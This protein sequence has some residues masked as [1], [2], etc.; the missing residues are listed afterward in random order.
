MTNVL[1][2]SMII[3]F[4]FLIFSLYF[5]KI[6]ALECETGKEFWCG[7]ACMGY[8][9]ICTCGENI[10]ANGHEGCC[11]NFGEKCFIG[12]SSKTSYF[13]V[14]YQLSKL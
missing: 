13:S 2:K 3:H 11:P 1:S 12:K 7:D 6:Q 14:S 8:F 9:D 4:A 5:C 10:V